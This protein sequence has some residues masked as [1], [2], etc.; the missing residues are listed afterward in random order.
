MDDTI[1][2]A[3][4]AETGDLMDLCKDEAW[5]REA[6]RIE[7]EAGGQVEAGL[8]MRKYSRAVNALTPE[9][10][11]RMRKQMRVESILFTTLRQWIKSWD[12]G[13]GFEDIYTVGRRLTRKR[14]SNAAPDVQELIEKLLSGHAESGSINPPLQQQAMAILLK[15]F[16]PEDQEI[17]ADTAARC[18]ESQVL[19]AIQ[20][21]PETIAV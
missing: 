9:Q 20:M 16:T 18:I 7:D 6:A 10:S 19:R 15:I 5:L 8:A 12:L 2:A 13:V 14:L 17:M 4:Y 3:Q 21:K 1:L 11:Q